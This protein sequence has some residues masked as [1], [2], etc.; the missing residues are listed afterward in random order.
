MACVLAQVEPEIAANVVDGDG[1]QQIVYVIS[2]QMCV[3]VGGDYF[4]DSV[5]Q[6][7]NRNV[8]RA[9]A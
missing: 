9:A 6:L 1:D 2:A 5:V 4:E 8:E 7:E 3:A